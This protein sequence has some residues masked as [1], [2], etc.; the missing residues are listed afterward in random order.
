[1][2]DHTLPNVSPLNLEFQVEYQTQVGIPSLI[3]ILD[4]EITVEANR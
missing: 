3:Q 1:M 4:K 2:L